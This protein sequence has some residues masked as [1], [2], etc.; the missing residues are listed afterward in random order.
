MTSFNLFFSL[1]SIIQSEIY[2]Y[3]DTYRIFG[4]EDFQ[5]ELTDAYLKTR[6]SF[7]KCYTKITQYIEELINQGNSCWHNEYGRIDPHDKLLSTHL[8]NYKSPEDF[9]IVSH[10]YYDVLYF[11]ILPKDA[12][13]ENCHFFHNIFHK[14]GIY[15]GYFRNEHK[16]YLYQGYLQTELNNNLAQKVLDKLCTRNTTMIHSYNMRSHLIEEQIGFYFII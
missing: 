13:Y 8:P 5:Q 9:L 10:Y 14:L 2:Q 12:C 16:Y 7:K 1:P 11:K 15:D 6:V 4:N 3:D